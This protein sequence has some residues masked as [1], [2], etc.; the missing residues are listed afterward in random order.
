MVGTNEPRKITWILRGSVRVNEVLYE[1]NTTAIHDYE[2]WPEA[3]T[4]SSTKA[5]V[6]PF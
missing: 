2:R 5:H 1:N 6:Y 3:V 4:I